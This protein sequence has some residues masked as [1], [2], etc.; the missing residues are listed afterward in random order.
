MSYKRLISTLT[1]MLTAVS[2]MPF[3]PTVN[4][5]ETVKGDINGDMSVNSE[6]LK[7]LSNYLLGSGKL[8]AEEGKAADLCKDNI[9]D[10]YDLIVLREQFK[11]NS[12][13]GLLI[14]E[15]CSSAKDSVTDASGA[16][17]DWIE[18]YNNSDAAMDISGVGVSDG[19]KNKFKFTFPQGTTIKADGYILIYCDDAVTEAAGEYH[20]A[21]KLS[22]TGETVYLTAPDGSEID[23]VEVPEL[24]TDITYGRYKNGSSDFR[25]LSYT[26]G[27]S[28]NDATDM[29][30]VEKPVFSEKGGFFDNEFQL[31]L[32]DNNGNE[33]YYTTDGSDPRTSD[34]AK[35]YSEGIR[36]YNNTNEP[37]VYSAIRDIT[38]TEYTPTSKKVEKGIVIRAASKNADGKFSEVEHNSYFVGKTAS[39]YKDM[40]VIS[41]ATDSDY[42]FDIDDGA[43]MI[44]KGYY[45]WL[46]SP[47]FEQLDPSDKNNPTNYNKEGRESE[48]PVSIQVIED[49][50]AVYNADLGA[51]ISGNW[52]RSAPQKS[53]RLVTRSEYGDT[54]IKYPL[55]TDLTDINGKELDRFDKVTLWN[56]GNDNQTLH[57][58]DALIQ[59]LAEERN[60]DTMG[61]EPC[62]LFIDGEFWGFYMLRERVDAEHLSNHFGLDEDDV[63]VIKNG[64]L[65]DGVES[66]LEDFKQFCTWAISAN[67]SN[68]LNYEKFCETVDVQS[69]IDYMAIETY[70]NNSDFASGYMNNWQ[71]WKSKTVHSDI[72]QA[73]GKWRFVLYDVDISCALY[74]GEKNM[75]DYD[76]L[77][78][79]NCKS[80]YFNLPAILKSL[81]RSDE[82]RQQ[83]YDSYV[84]IMNTVFDYSA[85]DEKITEYVNAY[86]KATTDTLKRFSMDWAANRYPQEEQRIREFFRDRPSYAKRYLDNY[87]D[88]SKIDFE[89]NLAT[90]NFWS[91]YGKCEASFNQA[92]NSFTLKVNTVQEKPWNIQSQAKNVLLEK[93]KTYT[94]S[95]KASCSTPCEVSLGFNHNVDGS[96][97]QC[98]SDEAEL[99]NELKE[100]TY[101]LTID[102]E[103]YYDWQLYFNYG[104]TAGTYKI[105]NPRLVEVK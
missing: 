86:E 47:E 67:M 66:D 49:G 70:V 43:Y 55:F 74:G 39:Y 53:F 58:R 48:F 16:S 72:P 78:N 87:C 1:A 36:I 33:I 101:T 62:L 23:T 50:K 40:K 73:N 41:M 2:A 24:N 3:M 52:T 95:F 100:F 65:D 63:A 57:F 61:S 102:E 22:A 12:Y 45:E 10:V 97:P 59:E 26:P 7:L 5:A 85:V 98:W 37:N 54:S 31:T 104:G 32:A 38:L 94:L 20:A 30:V 8:T 69:F 14:N 11:G 96:Y 83:F 80:Q 42:L 82:F 93:G 6:D 27:K 99:T 68:P 28:N 18:I 21:F 25:Y 44:G 88:E 64:S 103:T 79:N 105:V 13:S 29:D 76:S 92:E 35:L 51:K 19:S 34:T 84:E 75:A 81:I 77:G 46:R 71:V 89:N 4:A 90:T 9:L 17:P 15:V 60:V 91:Y 56:G